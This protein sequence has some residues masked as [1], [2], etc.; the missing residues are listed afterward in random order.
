MKTL[1]IYSSDACIH[2]DTYANVEDAQNAMYNQSRK[3]LTEFISP[4]LLKVS[5]DF[6]N[7][8]EQEYESTLEAM[9][10]KFNISIYIDGLNAY[11]ESLMDRKLEYI[12][13]VVKPF[14]EN[15]LFTLVSAHFFS[16]FD[17]M[18][19]E[20]EL[21]EKAFEIADDARLAMRE[22]LVEKFKLYA[23]YDRITDVDLTVFSF[24][25]EISMYGMSNDS[26]LDLRWKVF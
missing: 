24:D 10:E 7:M 3:S 20:N 26:T 14:D 21:K 16:T 23:G 19:D 15:A 18:D 13:C 1:L 11:I 22:D 4:N 5:L 25:D 17:H 2:A 9:E 8:D 6:L 12:H